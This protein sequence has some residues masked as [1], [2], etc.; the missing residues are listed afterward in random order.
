[1]RA[2]IKK[3][4]FFL[5]VMSLVFG[6]F[7]YFRL[8]EYASLK[9]LKENH[10]TLHCFVH[11]HYLFS[12]FLYVSFFAMALA[13]ALPLVMPFALL[14][15]FLYGIVWG[16]VY[17]GLSC[18]LGSIISYVALRY[19]FGNLIKEWH[20]KQVD[21][22]L[23]LIHKYGPSYLLVL[24]FLSIIPLFLIN[25]VAALAHV[26]LKKVMWITVAGTLPLNVLCAMAGRELSMVSSYK[27]IFSP[28]IM[29]SLAILALVSLVPLFLRKIKG[30]LGGE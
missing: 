18:L 30:F 17:A 2:R 22:F 25:V 4:L 10:K 27:D 20:S 5:L 15:G 6:L 14:G 16:V 8:H 7:Y 29:I 24:H 23:A 21:K 9:N 28:T 1:M 3:I 11:K 12:V 13:C 26:P 19:L